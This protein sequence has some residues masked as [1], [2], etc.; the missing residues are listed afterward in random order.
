MS[1]YQYRV[2]EDSIGCLEVPINALYGVQTQRAIRLYPLNGEKPLAAYPE[3][4]HGLLKVKKL[5]ALINIETKEIDAE[6]GQAVVATVDYLLEKMPVEQFQV[7][8]FH[9]GGGVSSNM[10]LNEVI[11]NV[12]NHDTFNQPLGSYYPIHPNDHVNLNNSTSDVLNTAC[13]LAVIDKR[14]ELTGTLQG[15]IDTFEV[16]ADKWKEV[17]KLSRTCLQDAVDISF[18]DM[19]GGYRAQLKRQKQRLDNSIDELYKINLGGNIIGRKGDCSDAFFDKIIG[20]INEMEASD[21]FMHTDN[22]FDASQSYDD[23]AKVAADLDQ[24]ARALLRIAKDFRLMASGPETGFGEIIL[25]AVQPGSSAMPGKI[26]P[27]IPEYLVQC[28]M[29]ACGHCYAVQM[30]QDHGELDYSPWQSIIISNLLDAMSVLTSG[31]QAFD[32]H[33]LSGMAPDI[34]R[35]NANVNTLIPTLMRLKKTHGYS[36]TARVYKETG[37]DLEKIRTYL[38]K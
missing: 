5:A 11:A 28:A 15:L 33:C 6:M 24:L 27:T 3:L 22:F 29:Q 20:N 31:M 9:G 21:R 12:A 18:S 14:K 13:H 32:Q 30:T 19:F 36:F 1:E 7:H 17:L 10:N 37:G 26:N 4:L 35:N 38:E 23:L 34:K 8:S 25:P 16:Q 2:E